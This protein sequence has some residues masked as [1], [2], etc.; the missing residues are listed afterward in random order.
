MKPLGGSELLYNNLKKYIGTDWQQNINLFL[1]ICDQRLIS[2][3]KTNILWQHLYTDQDALMG[4]YDRKFIDTV[5]QFVY[6]SN[7]QLDQFKSKFDIAS[8]NNIVI[9]NAIEPIEF[10]EKP[11]DRLRLIY[12][13]MPNRGLD[14]LL[15]A[16]ELIDRDVELVIYSS[17]IIYGKGY[18]SSMGN[19]YDRLF[20]RARSMKN[21]VYKGYA[22]NKDIR[23]ALQQSHILA[24]PST[25][26]ETSCMSA[27]EA[28]AAGCKIVTTD[29][30]ALTE[31]CNK[32]ATYVEY[33]DRQSLVEN[34]AQ[35][36]IETIDNYQDSMYTLKV[37]SD[38]FN[39][40]YSWENRKHEW[41]N[42]L[43]Q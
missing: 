28:G 38:W 24:Y 22:M 15:D 1:S 39:A 42:L 31:T 27:I 6:V 36:L 33:S 11:T 43:Q 9:K 29:L 14:V 41:I 5:D 20:A 12:T 37:Q 7:W 23:L 18:H 3:D 10:K 8:T 4:M 40:Q 19:T 2:S 32:Y 26:K 30:G 25:F 34:Y 17:N 21:V 16:F 35:S 13:S